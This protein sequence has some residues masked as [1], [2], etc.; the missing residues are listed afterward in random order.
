ML[1]LRSIQ[2]AVWNEFI[3]SNYRIVFIEYEYHLLLVNLPSDGHLG[4]F[5][6]STSTNIVWS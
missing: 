2:I 4:S 3:A 1:F 5:Q 6:L